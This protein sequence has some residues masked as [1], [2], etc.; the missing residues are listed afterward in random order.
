[1]VLF[2][3][4][5]TVFPNF[6]IFFIGLAIGAAAVMVWCFLLSE[7]EEEQQKPEDHADLNPNGDTKHED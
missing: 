2:A 1:V 6:E 4:L 7:G 3:K 5:S